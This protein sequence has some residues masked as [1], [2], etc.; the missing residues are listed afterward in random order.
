MTGVKTSASGVTVKGGSALIT[1][2][3]A[4]GTDGP[5]GAQVN[6]ITIGTPTATGG[7]TVTL[8]INGT[9]YSYTTVAG[10]T[11]AT[12]TTALLGK[13]G[14]PAGVVVQQ[15][16]PAVFSLV[17]ATA[18]VP[19]TS[20][21]VSTS[22]AGG[23]FTASDV[24][25]PLGTDTVTVSGT[26]G[27]VGATLAITI[28]GVTY[29]TPAQPAGTTASTLAGSLRGVL[30]ATLPAA[31]QVTPV[32]GSSFT[33]VG[34]AG[35]T[36][37][38]VLTYTPGAGS[39]TDTV[40][41]VGTAI[42]A[43]WVNG[44]WSNQ[45]FS[46][47]ADTFISGSGGGAFTLGSGGSWNPT[48]GKTSTGA[49]D[50][51]SET[52][53]LTAAAGAA[54]TITDWFGTVATNNGVAGGV[55]GF[56]AIATSKADKLGFTKNQTVLGPVTSG[57]AVPT[58]SAT[59]PNVAADLKLL[60]PSNNL[61]NLTYGVVN[62]L[63]TFGATGTNNV[64]QFS[65]ST[66]ITAAQSIVT[67]AANSAGADQVGAFVS[68]G[69]TYVVALYTLAGEGAYS[70]H[71][72]GASV[73]ELLG[74]GTVAGFGYTGAANTIGVKSGTGAPGS[75]AVTFV[76]PNSGAGN[77]G[78][79]TGAT[80]D[81]TGYTRDLLTTGA[82][83]KTNTF[84]NLGAF[85][86]LDI[87]GAANVPNIDLGNVALTQLGA[88]GSNSLVLNFTGST[89]L[90][91]VTT[92]G[93]YAI[94]IQTGAAAIGS[95]IATLTDATNTLTTLTI[96]GADN[97]DLSGSARVLG[98][99]TTPG[100]AGITGTA[101]T[102]I[103]ASKATGTV[104][105]TA[106]QNALT[107]KGSQGGGTI[108]ANGTGNTITF[109]DAGPIV[110][111]VVITANGSGDTIKLA[112]ETGAGPN[113]IGASAGGDTISVDAGPNWIG[114]TVTAAPPNLTHGLGAGDTVNL[115]DGGAVVASD[116]VWVGSATPSTWA[117]APRRSVPASAARRRSSRCPARP[118]G[119]PRRAPTPPP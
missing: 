74:V 43:G 72:Y 117:P 19:F 116:N 18:G 7:D 22:A 44:G 86:Q 103:D 68:G 118:P 27:L 65:A 95:S 75:P 91:T 76:L 32:S 40:T 53:N 62:G 11:A 26:T 102:T 24:N 59:N 98:G 99:F 100:G 57:T 79:A 81:D 45:T 80:Y 47:A 30:F 104:N 37:G 6:Q 93:D 88:S 115:G 5:N 73:T 101:L 35:T 20:S 51:G 2:A 108:T 38:A 85:A 21:I 25:S 94:A 112:G 109:G 77:K 89:A 29:T 46:A 92:S 82:T 70:N 111:G 31:F 58:S 9:S 96:T 34:P 114:G 69:N 12:A 15:T 55:T 87:T 83:L 105:L 28:N 66:L 84:N 3:G 119:P 14:T 10:D 113:L 67:T 52:V 107:I 36:G 33:I 54:D 23:V 16:A 4:Q 56:Q 8:W 60:D 106:G 50:S 48:G 49:F 41:A 63:I 1:A 78:T 13:I 90:E 64:S 42:P 61:S 97:L 17:G 71:L 39:T 110:G